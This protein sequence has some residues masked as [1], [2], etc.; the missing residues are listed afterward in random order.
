[1]TPVSAASSEVRKSFSEFLDDARIKPQ[2][3]KR[4]KQV[5]ITMPAESFDVVAPSKIILKTI[6]DRN[7]SFYTHNEVL[8]EIIGY[9]KAKEDAIDSFLDGLVSFAYEYYDNFQLYSA[10]PG[11][12]KQAP[13]IMKIISIFERGISVSDILEIR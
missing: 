10:S 3:I 4:R 1:M 9:G 11:R 6:R 12:A 5:F 7:G 13:I 8:P 2:Y